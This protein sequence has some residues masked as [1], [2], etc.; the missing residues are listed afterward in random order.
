MMGQI[1]SERE[2]EID[3]ASNYRYHI[4]YLRGQVKIDRE[5][6]YKYKYRYLRKKVKI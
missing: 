6:K 5:S 4:E 2:N 1:I 3:R